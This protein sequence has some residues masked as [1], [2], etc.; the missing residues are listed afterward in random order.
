MCKTLEIVLSKKEKDLKEFGA[1]AREFVKAK[2]SQ[3]WQSER[4]YKF[5]Q[6][7]NK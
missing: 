1:C 2:K 7:I 4:V 5:I 3:K 6:E